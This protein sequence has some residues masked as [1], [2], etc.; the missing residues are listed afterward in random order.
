MTTFRFLYYA[1]Q[2]SV[3]NEILPGK[4]AMIWNPS[5]RLPGNVGGEFKIG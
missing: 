5:G 4:V 2:S 1:S 3:S